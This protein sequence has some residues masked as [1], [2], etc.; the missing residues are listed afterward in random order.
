M[1][2]TE[3]KLDGIEAAN[4]YVHPNSGVTAGT[5]R[6]VTVNAAGHVTATNP[7]TLSGYGITDALDLNTEQTIS[8]GPK[9]LVEPSLLRHHIAAGESIM[10]FT[11]GTSIANSPLSYDTW[12]DHFHF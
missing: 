11:N 8:A 9:L 1:S 7:T 5:Y 3:S 10:Y 6:S 12:H 2:T 4:K